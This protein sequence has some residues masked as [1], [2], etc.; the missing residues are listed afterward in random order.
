MEKILG[1][2]CGRRVCYPFQMSQLL[3][4]LRISY[5]KDTEILL[6]EEV[7]GSEKSF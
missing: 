6:C 4:G 3:S 7:H 5:W 2:L 1:P